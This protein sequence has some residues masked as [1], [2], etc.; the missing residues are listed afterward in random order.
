MKKTCIG[1]GTDGEILEDYEKAKACNF[2][3]KFMGYGLHW[4]A[5]H[6]KESGEELC[7]SDYSKKAK[8]CG[9]FD[10][11]PDFVR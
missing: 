10:C 8:S 1:I 3:T 9:S 7:W 2:C 6:C 4:V 11:R 5:G